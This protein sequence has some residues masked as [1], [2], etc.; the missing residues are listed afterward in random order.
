MRYALIADVHGNLEAL[1][2][3]LLSVE[4]EK[5]D[6]ILCVGDIVGY[7][8][9]PIECIHLVKDKCSK[10][11]CGNHDS[12]AIGVTDIDFFNPFAKEAVLW[13]SERLSE[14]EINYLASLKLVEREDNFTMVHAT[15][16][17]PRDWGYILNTFD[18]AVTFQLQTDPVCFI[19]HSHVPVAYQKKENFIS[20]HRFIS[21]IEP[22]SQYIINVGSVG[23]S[24]DGDPRAS[25]VIY[26]KKMQTLRLKR[27]EYDISK[28]QKKILDAGL[29]QILAD[30]LSIG[31]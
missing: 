3:V 27:V 7:G 28:T 1:E 5:I 8:A 6:Q 24:R 31:R 11:I 10:S 22:D 4:K 14:E 13:T 26:D 30:R 29:P 12:A 25:Y 20:G 17:S 16:D 15:L 21:K 18:A 23:Q 19:G 9:D 2:A